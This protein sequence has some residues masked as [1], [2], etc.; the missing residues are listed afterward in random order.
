MDFTLSHPLV[1]FRL[2]DLELKVGVEGRC[3]SITGVTEMNVQ[4]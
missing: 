2:S 1:H 4:V 3:L